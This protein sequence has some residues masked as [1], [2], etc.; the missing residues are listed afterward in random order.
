MN[1]DSILRKRLKLADTPDDWQPP[2]AI[3]VIVACLG[4]TILTLILAGMLKP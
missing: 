4:V 3:M 1:W 2:R